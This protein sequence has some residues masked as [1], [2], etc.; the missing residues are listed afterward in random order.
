[1]RRRHPGC[2]RT[3]RRSWVLRCNVQI[4]Q[5]IEIKAIQF[6]AYVEPDTLE[7]KELALV[8]VAGKTSE[9]KAVESLFTQNEMVYTIKPTP[10]MR[11]TLFGGLVELPGVGFYVPIEQAAYCRTLLQSRKFK[12]GLVLEGEE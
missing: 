6:M 4:T 8:Y 7:E 2:L 12:A 11:S 1:M 5:A 9:V 10:F 3:V